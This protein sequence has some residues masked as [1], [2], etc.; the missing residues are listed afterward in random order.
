MGL[1]RIRLFGAALCV[2]MVVNATKVF[3]QDMVQETAGIE[4]GMEYPRS[5]PTESELLDRMASLQGCM[6]LR[7]TSAVKSYISTY[8]IKK[9]DKANAML[10]RRLTYFPLFEQKL[11]EQGLP[12][13]LKY[14]AVVE[15]A[16][17]P[18]AV[19]HAGAV[20][21]W[22]F[23]P[24][25]GE[26][27]GLYLSKAVDERVDPVQST[28]AAVKYLK[29]LHRQYND[30]ALALAAYN[31]GPGRVNAA[32]KRARSRNFWR[33]QAFL[34]TETRNYV[35]AFIAASYICN[36]HLLHGLHPQYPDQDEQMTAYL[37]IFETLT[38]REIANAT[39][40][41]YTVIKNLNPAY[42]RDYVPGSPSGYYVV[43]PER[44][45]PA[46]VRFLNAKG[47][48]IYLWESPQ[49]AQGNAPGDGRYCKIKVQVEKT[50]H[51]ERMAQVL[52]CPVDHLKAWNMLSTN[53]VAAGE[54]LTI[55]R[56]V[57][58]LNHQKLQLAAPHAAS[59][60]LSK[61]EPAAGYREDILQKNECTL[62]VPSSQL[63]TAKEY[64]C[65]TLRRNESLDEVAKQ[66]GVTST[67]IQQLNPGNTFKT[68]S[69]LKVK[70][71]NR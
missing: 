55:W 20:G 11:K 25:T 9:S 15:S 13:D 29:N 2:F 6:P 28:E 48:H 37:K 40:V 4:L 46:F 59:K 57:N 54:S 47:Q 27:Y 18:L 51:V 21:L 42:R 39:G 17:N 8:V 38:F 45:M 26:E 12:Q 50:D 1:V 41:E 49:S 44:V 70:T 34:P 60:P 16:L 58:T 64:V 30:W 71:I 63:G 19:S 66:Y 35:P 23:M 7:V 33:I 56:P 14:L 31:S 61:L 53:Y 36:Y 69:R 67:H 52:Q 65:H 43:L 3:A 22:Q 68:G 24:A 62:E 32:I 10:G 5:M